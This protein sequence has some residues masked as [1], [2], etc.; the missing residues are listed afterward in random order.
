[1]ERSKGDER[2]GTNRWSGGGGANSAV[3]IRWKGRLRIRDKT[4]APALVALEWE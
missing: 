3:R 4:V 1:M 2:V